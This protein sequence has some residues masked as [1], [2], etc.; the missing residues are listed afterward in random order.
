MKTFFFALL[1]PVLSFANLDYNAFQGRFEVGADCLINSDPSV[2]LI[3]NRAKREV[4]LVGFVSFDS[5]DQGKRPFNSCFSD[6]L[7]GYEQTTGS[8]TKVTAVTVF[9]RPGVMC[10]GSN[11]FPKK[12]SYRSLE[13]KGDDLIYKTW[14]TKQNSTTCV[15][16]RIAN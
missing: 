16:K 8:G 2:P 7:V 11:L 12:K 4:R 14:G 6:G 9:Q 10:Q 5:I 13:I 15:L 1:F 3:S